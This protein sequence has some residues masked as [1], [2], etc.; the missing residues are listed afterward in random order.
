MNAFQRQNKRREKDWKKSK[1]K[2]RRLQLKLIVEALAARSACYL[3][4]VQLAPVSR[5]RALAK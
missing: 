1:H 5:I 2:R 3:R 4:E